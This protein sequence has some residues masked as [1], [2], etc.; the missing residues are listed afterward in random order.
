M[1][2]KIEIS[3]LDLPQDIIITEIYPKLSLL[4][5]ARLARTSKGTKDL[6]EIPLMDAKLTRLLE[7]VAFG[8]QD[9]AETIVKLD[10]ALLL[11]KGKVTDGSGRTFKNITVFQYAV[12]ALDWHMWTMLL[13]Y[14]TKE[15]AGQ[16]LSAW[17]KQASHPHGKHAN[18]QGLIDAYTTYYI[19]L[20]T[21]NRASDW[22][23]TR[24]VWIQQI[25]KAQL[26]L[27]AHVV[28]EYCHG[29]RAFSPLP[30]FENGKVELTRSRMSE[31]VDWYDV[32]CG[33]EWGH[34]RANYSV[35]RVSDCTPHTFC[36]PWVAD[37]DRIA[38]AA[39]LETR[40][41]QRYELIK[42]L[43][44]ELEAEKRLHKHIV[45]QVNQHID[46]FKQAS[47]MSTKEKAREFY[48]KG[49]AAFYTGDKS[50]AITFF[51]QAKDS[52][53]DLLTNAEVDLTSKQEAEKRLNKIKNPE[54][55]YSPKK[56]TP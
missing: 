21:E 31:G 55:K 10:P 11:M 19:S 38:L 48:S 4:D 42:T 39:L 54:G 28:N 45:E 6:F 27:P 16:Q 13:K 18:W 25:G 34:Y 44:E 53:K 40:I 9:Q 52:Y 1:K 15:E 56:L 50:S 37:Y 43:E 24:S 5:L 12:W 20:V 2:E 29:S 51:L 47:R 33:V 3:I 36:S 7:L 22:G 49:K 26:L 46:V 14:L 8:E 30:D 32:R 17:E 23:L 35:C 41:H